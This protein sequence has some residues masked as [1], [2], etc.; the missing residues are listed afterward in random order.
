[1][2]EKIKILYVDD[3]PMNLMLFSAM[4]SDNYVVIE[5]GSGIEALEILKAEQDIK[6]V[7]S[8]MKMPRMDGME[9][10][11]C[12]KEVSPHIDFYMLSGYEITQ[13]VQEAIDAGLIIKYFQKPFMRDVIDKAIKASGIRRLATDITLYPGKGE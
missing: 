9:F 2:E 11:A 10:I 7:I 12:A 6:V 8:D 3:E 1:M 13:E 5:S 4:F